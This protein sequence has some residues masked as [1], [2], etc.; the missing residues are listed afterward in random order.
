MIQLL[1]IG[2]LLGHIFYTGAIVSTIFTTLRISYIV[3]L[4]YTISRIKDAIMERILFNLLYPDLWNFMTKK[5]WRFLG[6]VDKRIIVIEIIR[7]K[8]HK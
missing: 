6:Q 7:I 3:S 4:P 2:F 1:R 5:T 8:Q